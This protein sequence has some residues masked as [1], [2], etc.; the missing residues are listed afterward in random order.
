VR[1]LLWVLR[2][3]PPAPM[4][5]AALANHQQQQLSAAGWAA[6]WM[7]DPLVG[8]PEPAGALARQLSGRTACQG[9]RAPP[10]LMRAALCLHL[11]CFPIAGIAASPGRD[12]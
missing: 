5:S 10:V 8:A 12:S 9:V 1:E 2:L 4:G 3:F 11:A 6:Y 7:L